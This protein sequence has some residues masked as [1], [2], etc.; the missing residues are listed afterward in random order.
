MER[1]DYT[2]LKYNKTFLTEVITRIDFLGQIEDM[3]ESLPR[4]IANLISKSFP[5][6]EPQK[7]VAQQLQLTPDGVISKEG[8]SQQNL[9]KFFGAHREKYLTFS[10]D[11]ILASYKKYDSF[12]DFLSGILPL[13]EYLS[14]EYLDLQARRVGLRYINNLKPK[15][16]GPFSWSKFINEHMLCILDVLEPK[17]AITRA[18]H[19]LEF[20]YG[21]FRLR[22]QYGIHNS[23][24]PAPVRQRVF[25][26]D[27]DAFSET[28]ESMSN[29]PRLLSEYH[30]AIQY[31]FEQSITDDLREELNA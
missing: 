23:D 11:A 30:D 17:K 9:W 6:L 22:F 31:A 7:V 13:V 28:P 25:V 21:D 26:M 15:G 2:N 18:F 20:N 5:I 29:V 1:G 19:N 4:K 27:L 14:K 10:S 3:R 8:P 24:Y 12:E 16:R